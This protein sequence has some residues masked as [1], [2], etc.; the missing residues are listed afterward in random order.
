MRRCNDTLEE[1]NKVETLY[2]DY[3]GRQDITQHEG[4]KYIRQIYSCVTPHHISVDVYEVFKAFD[5]QCPAT[6]HAIKKLLCAG[7]RAKGSRMDD[8]K[9]AMAALN[10]AIDFEERELARPEDCPECD[11]NP[12]PLSFTVTY[13][14]EEKLIDKVA[15]SI[16]NGD[17]IVQLPPGFPLPAIGAEVPME[18]A[19]IKLE[20]TVSETD[21]TNGKVVVKFYQIGPKI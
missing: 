5:V 19:N 10:R 15:S 11:A 8:L 6:Q 20:G 21:L 9:G 13:D 16:L 12:D 7:L 18:I 1:I 2:G 3:M 4:N 17:V 14:P